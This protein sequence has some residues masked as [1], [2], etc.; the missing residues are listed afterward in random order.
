MPLYVHEVEATVEPPP[1]PGPGPGVLE[2]AQFRALV[3]A[4]AQELERRAQEQQSRHAETA[5]TGHNRP[6]GIGS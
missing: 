4:V 2:P 6:P 1:D 5:I 3:Q